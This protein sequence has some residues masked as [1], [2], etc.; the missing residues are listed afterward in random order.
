MF[1][2]YVTY[3]WRNF[4]PTLKLFGDDCKM[5]RKIMNESD[6]ETLQLDLDGLGK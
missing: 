5:Y 4:E 3:I 6:M 1:L 2:A